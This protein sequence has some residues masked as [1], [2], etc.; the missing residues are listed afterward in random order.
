MLKIHSIK[1][2]LI[3]IYAICGALL[4]S[5][6]DNI[7]IINTIGCLLLGF[8][9][10]LKISR[11]QKIFFGIGFCGSLTTYSKWIMYISLTLDKG[12]YLKSFFIIS[13][14]LLLGII[15]LYLGYLI[16]NILNKK[17]RIF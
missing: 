7:L 13:S 4:S 2:F 10:T 11:K 16:A 9:N 6:V 3:S 17:F 12:L 1:Y 8:I 5:L 15:F 14:N